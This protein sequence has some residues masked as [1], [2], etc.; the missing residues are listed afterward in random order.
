MLVPDQ[1]LG[2][3][4][5]DNLAVGV[6]LRLQHADV[7]VIVDTAGGGDE[8]FRQTGADD[9]RAIQTEDR[10][11]RN[12]TVMRRK[13]L[14]NVSGLGQTG[15]MVGNINVVVDMAVVGRKMASGHTKGHVS[16]LDG[17][18]LNFNHFVVLLYSQGLLTLIFYLLSPCFVKCFRLSVDKK[19]LFSYNEQKTVEVLS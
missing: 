19:T 16:S 1:G 13:L 4:A 18:F 14:G 7:A 10:V 6:V 11:D 3:V 17:Q 5:E 15:L 2:V 8:L 12:G 9:S